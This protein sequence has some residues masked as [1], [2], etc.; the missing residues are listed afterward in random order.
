MTAPRARE[1]RRPPSPPDRL[2]SR[3]GGS[4][5]GLRR[6]IAGAFRRT[7][8]AFLVILAAGVA[9]APAAHA[10]VTALQATMTV[11]IH[12]NLSSPNYLVRNSGY[13]RDSSYGTM[14]PSSFLVAG[15]QY[16]VGRL[17]TNGEG[18]P[19]VDDG[20]VLGFF[21][22]SVDGAVI[23]TDD[24]TDGVYVLPKGAD[25]TLHLEGTDWSKSYSLQSAKR[26]PQPTP[27]DGVS[28]EIGD[29]IWEQYSW[30]SDFPPLTEGEQVMVRLTLPP[31]TAPT[32][33]TGLMASASG[34]ARID[35]SWTAPSNGGSAITG[36]KIEVS[37]DGG[38]NWT[39]L[40]ADTGDTDTRHS[41][42][43]LSPGS[44]R[45]YRVSA[46]NAV[47]TSDASDVVSDTT[48][49]SCTL[50]TGDRWCG[51]VTVANRN[52]AIYG[53]FP[54]YLTLPAAG[55]L[56]DKTFDSY[57]IEG[58]WTG[59]VANAGKLFFDLTS[60]LSAADKARLVLHVGRD[61]FAFSAAP[62]P[63]T[64]DTYNWEGTGLDWSSE[65]YVTLRLRLRVPGKPTNLAAE[66]N[67]TTQ[68]DLTWDAPASDSGVTSHEYRYKTTGSYT[69]WTAITDSGVGGANEA[70]FTVRGLT[71]E[72]AHTFEL[73]ALSEG[74]N[75][76]EATGLPV[77]PTPGIC[78]RTQQVQDE[79]LNR[80]SAVSACAAVTV[81]D[82]ASVLIL[83]ME[84]KSITSLK[85]DD[86][87]G[88]TAVTTIEVAYNQLGALPA[89]LFSG[90][91]TLQHLNIQD[92]GVTTLPAD[93]FS[94]LT[95]LTSL[96]LDGNKVGSLPANQFSGLRNLRAIQL[97]S[98][99][100]TELP[101]GL[102]SG[103]SELRDLDV[104]GNELTSLPAG[105]FSGL[106]KL[107]S[108]KLG[109]N[110]LT[111]TSLPDGVFS[112]LTGLIKLELLGNPDDGSPD[113]PLL[114]TVTV[115]KVGTDRVRAKVLVGAPF[116]VDIP[117]TLVG[118]TL[119]GGATALSVPAGAVEGEPVTVTR[120]AGTT[121]AVTVDVDLTDQ[122]ALP[123]QHQGYAFARASSGLPET[124]LPEE[125]TLPTPTNFRATPGDARVAL[126]WDA[127]APDA[128]VTHHEYRYKTSGDYKNWRLISNSGPG[129]TNASGSTVTGLANGT[130]HTFELRARGAGAGKSLAATL[131]VTPSGP[132]RIEGVAVT[133]SPGLDG[134]TYGRGE[135]IRI[136]VTFDQPVQVEGDPEF[137]LDAGGP[138]LAGYESGSGTEKL[139]FAYTVLAEDSDD[140]GIWIGNHDHATNRTFRL[141]GNDRIGN[142]EGD[143][144]ELA[145]DELGTQSGHKVDGS[146]KGGVH[147]HHVLDHSHSHVDSGKRY[148]TQEY[149]EHTHASHEHGN[150]ANNHPSSWKRPGGHH[151]HQQEGGSNGTFLGPDILK[152]DGVE[153]T[154]VCMD[155]KPT[156][157]QGANFYQLGDELGLPIK[158]TH[159][160]EH[161]EPGHRYDWVKY[162]EDRESEPE[163]PEATPTPAGLTATPGNARVTLAWNAPGP[164]SGVTRHE[165]RYKTSGDYPAAWRRIANSGPGGTNASGFTVT[166][167]ANGTA[168]TF[169]LRTVNA[170]GDSD[171]ATS[172]AVTPTAP[173]RITRVAVTSTPELDGDTYG[174]G[175]DIR[176]TVTFDQPVRV[177]GDPEFGLDVGGPRVAGYRTGSGTEKLVFVYTVQ[178]RELDYTLQAD[179]LDDNGIWIGTDIHPT[180]PTFRLDG[181]DRI[182]NALG[183]QDAVLAH[184]GLGTQSGHK[185]DGSRKSGTHSHPEF[186]HGHAHDGSGKGYYT[187]EYADHRHASHVHDD[188]A[189]DNNHPSGKRPGQHHHHEQQEPN[190]TFAGPDIL[191]HDEVPHTHV[192]M[193]I[194]PGCNQGNNFKFW[195]GEL[196]LP[197]EV[198][199]DHADSEP[200][201]GYDWKTY[202]EE[203]E[204][205]A[206]LMG[207][208][209]PMPERHDGTKRITA[210]VTFSEPIDASEEEMSEHGV[211]VEGGRVRSA[212]RAPADGNGEDAGTGTA[213]SAGTAKS[214]GTAR[215]PKDETATPSGEDSCGEPGSTCTEDGTEDGKT[216]W[217]FEIEPDSDG[218]VTVRID[219]G[220]PC[221]EPGAVCT[222]DGRSLSEG[223]STTVEGPEP[224]PPPLTA[225]FPESAYASAQHKGPSDR[226]QVVVAFS[227]PVAA[228][229]ADTPSVSAT[230][231]SVDVVQRLDKEGLENAYVF[232]LT[233]EGH[234]AIVFRLHANRAC[235]DGGICTADRRRLS[236]SPSATVAGPADE[237]ERNTAAAGAP[238]IGGTAQVGEELTASTSGI[239]DADGLD[240]ASFAYQWI[241][242]GVD[243]GGASAS[244]YTPVAADEGER[245]KVRVGFTD[246]AGHEESLTSAGT[247]AVVGAASTVEPLTARFARAPAEHDGK[248]AFKLRIRFSEDIAISFRRFRDQ[249]LS[250]SGGS[251]KKAKRVDRRR[252][253]WEVTVKPGSLGDVTVTLEGGH[254]CGTAGAVC[255][256][257]GRALSTTISTTVLGPVAL[258]VA[259]ARV[260]EA[261]DAL[262]VFQVTLDRARHAAVTVD[263]VT[264]DVTARAGEDYTSA[265]GTLTFAT[266]EREKTVSVTVF[267]DAHDEGEETLALALSNPSG[268]YLADAT[269]TGTIENTDPMP[270]AW[271]VRFGRTVGSQVVDA[272]N[273]RLDG[274]GGSHVTV[275]GINLVGAPGLEPQA[276]DDD[277]FGLPEWAKNAEREADA[278]TITAEDIRLRSAFHLSSG[279]DGT[280]GG[281]PAFTAWGR[282]ATGGFEAE[283]DD[284]AMDGDVTTGLVGFDAEW[285][286]ALA[287]VMLSQSSGDGSYR[288]DPA[289][290]D[291]A[292]TVESSL[293]GVYPYA[294][295]DLNRQVSAWA[296]AGVGSGELTLRQT[297]E[298]AMPTDISMRMGAV[299]VKGK[300]LD[301]TGAS[302]VA[303]NVKSD[304]MWVG[305]KSADTSELA[306]TEG[307]VTRLR[308]IVEGERG[309]DMG[310]GSTFT[311]SAEV[312]LRH[313]G[314]DAETGTGVEV[315]AGLRYTVGAVTIEAQARTLLVHEA[316]GYEDWGASGAIRVTPDASGRG[317]TLSIAPVW[318]RTGSAAERLWSAR[319]A[320]ALGGDSEFEADS[321]IALDAGYGFGL[322]HRRGV[323]TPYAGLTLGDAGNR[324]VRT[325]TRWQVS[326]DT[327]FGLE[328]TRQ[329]SDTAEADNQ[330]MLRAA[331]RF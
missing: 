227:A 303:L 148:Y 168:H 234:Q 70:S 243:I 120:T 179:D 48:A 173:P 156:C 4:P 310:G 162:F 285:E 66:A 207:R 288:L 218:D 295:V 274:A 74:G 309:F 251:V 36:Y 304:A 24:D 330:L 204:S 136:E 76:P 88:L 123:S 213:K 269:A 109:V 208:F 167:L 214:T 277:P 228:F 45:H 279:G 182:A 7:A 276:E 95:A 140:N 238:T 87:A 166:G 264:S 258:S 15:A 181:G 165:Y 237:P 177:E 259:D 124:V 247:D 301:G 38:T 52:S 103:L 34:D 210:K 151:H 318:G 41:H 230:G 85:A 190:G 224:G 209:D 267:D 244:T 30:D 153:H 96:F 137:G 121:A 331:L 199:H 35:L 297:G 27:S 189:D 113:A 50:N 183:H 323:L 186:T 326:P 160:H 79:I 102:F 43:G 104:S 225:T 72:V 112:G 139:L 266:G 188:A 324:T 116:A 249:V 212:R 312:G 178:S 280:H 215:T 59:T 40:V 159:A 10:Q 281:G 99:G 329:A 203:R 216:V 3:R 322:A 220:R 193:D 89:K 175:D 172:E 132:P 133:S 8:A 233:P 6:R 2:P 250:V 80:L 284:V 150:T 325:G 90:L 17:N 55:D 206:P 75:S 135:R 152:H 126:T 187:E 248:T 39:D 21:T 16:T 98:I 201:H 51:V 263:Y 236:N 307:D 314:G 180:N 239:S 84:E 293:T 298:K 118:G 217:E 254:A 9:F 42:T 315:G 61:S 306:P 13:S 184:G 58:V 252:D 265:R 161:S 127:P 147:S 316:S 231:A 257:D 262:L 268:A 321:R 94:G 11:G 169:E 69:G 157:N 164:D 78:D 278:R 86:F 202:F 219:G 328:A 131:A 22:I 141:D 155:I 97:G 81:A 275:A 205:E 174:A 110:Q 253:L 313:D 106:S 145:H 129:E 29:V 82:L 305:T 290:G 245:L 255:T 232:F 272:L 73:R 5:S 302:G 117:V 25:F 291:D 111:S 200:G 57:T 91:T 211:Q 300:V 130:E 26:K 53:F 125:A 198:T 18:N 185:V 54:A 100:M 294:R 196:G 242:T 12:E 108:L 241:R 163:E 171:A 114:L 56:S 71:N 143:A 229:G 154:H 63:D 28:N 320:R 191:R 46:I 226:P 261:E 289:K 319:D 149:A 134:D 1:Q 308:F 299:G 287:G 197:I 221:D 271:M 33:P 67:G 270:K 92:S 176:I 93:A 311:P 119:A 44:T 170:N 23:S 296:L 142:T 286:R 47:G 222:A 146:R 317:L 327:T 31:P 32:A 128:G 223:I 14:N 158:V 195:A 65:T 20:I 122:P 235:P 68:I 64:F 256:G 240:N 138:R 105:V 115:E 292:G 37:T 273:A 83:V 246:D 19:N 60:A 282:V 260:R 192:C 62:G 194:K 283:E 101:A 49:T 77:T 144:A 107:E